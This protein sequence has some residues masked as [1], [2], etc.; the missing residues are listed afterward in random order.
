LST[1]LSL[2]EQVFLFRSLSTFMQSGI[3]LLRSLECLAQQGESAAVRQA[4]DHLAGEL[5]IG[6]SLSA[7][8]AKHEVCADFAVQLLRCAER[9]GQLA[10][11][12]ERLALHYVEQYARRARLRAALTYPLIMLV[13]SLAM[14]I[15]VP[16]VLLKDLLHS[17]ES[18]GNLPWPTWV[19]VVTG[20]LASSAWF[21]LLLAGALGLLA[22][23]QSFWERWKLPLHTL[24]A[25]LPG[26]SSFYRGHLQIQFVTCLALQL[27]AGLPLLSSL[28]Q[29]IDSTGSPLLDASRAQI[30]TAVMDGTPLSEALLL[31][32]LL[33]ENLSILLEAG[34]EIGRVGSVLEWTASLTRAR[35]EYLQDNLITLLEPLILLIMGI[36][37][38]VVTTGTLLPTFKVLDQL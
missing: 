6:S 14:A 1:L 33:S 9:S 23:S 24:L 11:I 10:A 35:L 29:A 36:V 13:A 18:D 25:H 8:L 12:M 22:R 7:A 20:E 28:R 16:T 17:F 38:G 4:S 15:L 2:K 32:P 19:L 27:R 34:E 26:A 37:V 21:W 31:E 3:P 30:L 5:L